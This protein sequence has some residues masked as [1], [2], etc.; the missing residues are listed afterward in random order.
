MHYSFG[1]GT[2]KR[3]KV[4][5]THMIQKMYPEYDGSQYCLWLV[6]DFMDKFKS[7][8]VT[9]NIRILKKSGEEVVIPGK[10]VVRKPY[11]N[12]MIRQYGLKNGRKVIYGIP[13]LF[14]SYEELAEIHEIH[15]EWG[16]GRPIFM[17]GETEEKDICIDNRLMMA[18]IRYFNVQFEE[19][20]DCRC[21]TLR[22]YLC[23][24]DETDYENSD[25]FDH[26]DFAGCEYGC[27]E[28]DT[29]SEALLVYPPE[30][31]NIYG[32]T[33]DRDMTDE[34]NDIFNV[35]DDLSFDYWV[36]FLKSSGEDGKKILDDMDSYAKYYYFQSDTMLEALDHFDI[37]PESSFGFESLNKV[38]ADV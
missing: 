2:L 27:M 31:H 3:V 28:Y 9:C 36:H 10:H 24:Y 7:S 37:L 38:G 23:F 8:F 4:S 22:S 18:H 20:S 30:A 35:M 34:E 33:E 29:D 12:F 21:Y 26:L 16:F 25:L 5:Q 11:P 15:I 1:D 32:V 6:A 14:S 13:L 17:K 19:K